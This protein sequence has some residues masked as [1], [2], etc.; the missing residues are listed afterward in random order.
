MPRDREEHATV[1]RLRHHQRAVAGEE[2]AVE[3]DVRALARDDERLRRRFI[4]P[5]DG[6]G[7]NARRVDHDAGTEREVTSTLG[8]TRDHAADATVGFQQRGDGAVVHGHAAEIVE[9]LREAD[10]EARVVELAVEVM[11]SAG[12]FRG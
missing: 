2:R 7:E 8:V 6:V 9:R 11:D 12:E 1:V 3:D 10:R 4:E 5:P